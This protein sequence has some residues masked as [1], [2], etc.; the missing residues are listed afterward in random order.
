MVDSN[1]D[2][3]IPKFSIGKG[4]ISYAITHKMLA[5]KTAEFGILLT[6]MDHTKNYLNDTQGG[7]EGIVELIEISKPT[8]NTLAALKDA[9]GGGVVS[10]VI[11]GLIVA[12]D[13]LVRVNENKKYTRVAMLIT[14]GKSEVDIDDSYIQIFVSK[15]ITIN[16]IV[17]GDEE[18]EQ[19]NRLDYLENIRNLKKLCSSTRGS[20]S[21]TNKLAGGFPSLMTAPGLTSRPMQRKINFQLSPEVSIPCTFWTKISEFKLPS[22]KKRLVKPSTGSSASGLTY[23]RVLRNPSDPDEILG[24]DDRVKGYKYGSQYIPFTLVDEKML[25]LP[26]TS[27]EPTLQLL[28]FIPQIQVP[29]H[30]FIDKPS[31]LEAASTSASNRIA[32]SGLVKAM[33]AEGQVALVRFTKTASSDPALAVLL[34]SQQV[35]HALLIHLL[36]FAEDVRDHCFPSLRDP[37]LAPLPTVAQYHLVSA[38]VDSLTVKPPSPASLEDLQL[39][40]GESNLHS[41]SALLALQEEE[42]RRARLCVFDIHAPNHNLF[43]EILKRALHVS[44]ENELALTITSPYIFPPAALTVGSVQKGSGRSTDDGVVKPDVDSYPGGGNNNMPIIY[45][46]QNAF[47]LQEIGKDEEVDEE[48]GGLDGEAAGRGRNGR[49]KRKRAAFW[50]DIHVQ[51]TDGAPSLS[52]DLKREGDIKG[53]SSATRPE[54]RGEIESKDENEGDDSR[55]STSLPIGHLKGSRWAQLL[56]P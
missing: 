21:Y 25:K 35:D 44:S 39:Q 31:V 16:V 41:A 29:R 13:I 46:L 14:D 9:K 19:N 24:F 27:T 3:F 37:R 18:S 42:E 55:V 10:D 43:S 54:E 15:D 17:V 22:L 2:K 52:T 7:Y 47:P 20:F 26:T 23:D 45:Q 4:M 28:G 48:E 12:L 1:S 30:H 53:A 51:Q 56:R 36:P 34:P 49:G 38:Y 6:G 5:S 32:L 50:S 8:T 33:R 40:L 11:D